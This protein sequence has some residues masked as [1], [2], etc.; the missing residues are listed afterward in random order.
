MLFGTILLWTPGQQQEFKARVRLAEGLGFDVVGVGDSPTLY[1][2]WGAELAVAASVSERAWLGP[3]VASPHGR[4]PVAAA[5]L[6]AS[7]HEMTGGRVFFGAG[8]GGSGAT[9]TGGKA[10]T[11]EELRA[12]ILALKSLM[13]G[14]QA[15]WAD[16]SIPAVSGAAQVPIYVSGY[17]PAAMRLAGEIADG[18]ILAVGASPELI[19]SY[20]GHVTVGAE[21]AGRTIDDIEFWTLSRVS[22]RD[23]RDEAIDDVKANLASGAAFGLKSTVQMATV[24]EEFR[25]AVAELQERYD[26]RHHV[27]WDGPNARLVDELGLRDYLAGRFGVVGTPQECLHQV[28]AMREA[29]ISGILVPAVDRDS[30]GVLT[31]F[32]DA[33]IG[34]MRR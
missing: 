9:A 17:G 31:R 4:H 7:V 6:L 34:P 26:S 22:V 12:Y 32:A 15:S 23:S 14:E 16:L 5:N 27:V 11:I 2:D 1:R 21:S 8:T 33:V 18:V 3:T 20:R 24:P 25:A 13:R 28:E 10:A 29:G 30:E 19:A